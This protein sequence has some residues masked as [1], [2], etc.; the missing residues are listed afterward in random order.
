MKI[1]NKFSIPLPALALALTLSLAG[2]LMTTPSARAAQAAINL[3]TATPFAILA[4]TPSISD[5]APLSVITGN[6][7][8][9]PASGAGIGLVC[10]QVTGTIYSVDASGPLPCRV[11]DGPLLVTAKNDL[12][13]A[14]TDAANRTPVN[15]VPTEL[16]GT[17]KIA[18]VYT[19]GATTF[20]ITAGAGP[21]VLDGQGDPS[22]IFIFESS[23]ASP[24]LT[25]GV[26][27]TVSLINGAQACNV[28]WRVVSADINTTATFK[29][30]ILALNSIT[31][32]NG[33]NIEGRL[34]ARNG[35]VSLI[36]DTITVPTCAAPA[37]GTAGGAGSAGAAA[38]A[39]KF[40]NA[41]FAPRAK[42]TPWNIV[43]IAS[44]A[45]TA[46]LIGAARR[47]KLI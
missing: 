39:P 17:T 15:T 7:G 16:G 38:A 20:D 44:L 10:S 37:A 32:A 5:T 28:F 8:M 2:V 35:L 3:G 9:S 30:T 13:A 12:D 43:T 23:A 14:Y 26:G 34:L 18:G 11:T 40:P 19:S 6:V 25:V 4:G 1:L 31:V 29:G 45:T 22:S 21:L 42:T 41:G 27:S 33:A 24:G 46:I 36:N 47:K